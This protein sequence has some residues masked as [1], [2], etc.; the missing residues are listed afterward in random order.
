MGEAEGLR[1]AQAR[2][3][4]GDPLGALEVL[5]RLGDALRFRAAG[6]LLLGRAYYHCA[7]LERA[8]EALELSV[9]LDPRNPE[10]RFVLGR[11]LE[12]RGRPREA[13]KQL[14]I[15]AAV[16]GRADYQRHVDALVATL[17]SAA[18]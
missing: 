11:T 18:A 14:R 12:R 7:Q 3:E 4:D 6:Q 2:L 5:R 15:A 16:S 1:A 17:G 9:A 8:Q 10:A 13:L